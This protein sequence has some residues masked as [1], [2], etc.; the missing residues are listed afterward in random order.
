M[1]DML[2]VVLKQIDKL[3]TKFDRHVEKTDERLDKYNEALIRNTMTLE[4]H[5]KGSIATNKRL[6]LM[7]KI[8]QKLVARIEHIDTHV[9]RIDH[10]INLF[11]P[12][13]RKLKW[14]AALIGLITSGYG[15]YMILKDVKF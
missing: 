4:E 12:T 8:V 10:I 13:T 9:I 7:E 1:S 5:V 3:D 11:K 14:L 2:D 6:T 15:L